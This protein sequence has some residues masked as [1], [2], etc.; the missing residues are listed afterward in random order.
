M[1]KNNVVEETGMSIINDG[2]VDVDL[3]DSLKNPSSKMYCSIENDGSRESQIKIYNAIASAEKK[4]A[5]CINEVIEVV[6]VAAHP[7]TLCDENT[8][9]VITVLRT[10]LIDKKGVA[11]AAVSQGITNSLSR[12]FGIVGQPSWKN[13]PVKMKIRQVQTRNDN[14]K[15]LTIELIK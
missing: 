12:I 10:I 4:I 15:V 8:G 2:I 3:I 9:E 5:D 11:Y 6:D 1:E 7:V 13:E 14:N